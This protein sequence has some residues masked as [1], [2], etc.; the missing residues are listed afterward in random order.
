LQHVY[1]F[2]VR[3]LIPCILANLFFTMPP[4]TKKRDS[5]K[6]AENKA[7]NMEVERAAASKRPASP[8]VSELSAP[9][10]PAAAVA[11]ATTLTREM[12]KEILD[13]FA[14]QQRDDMKHMNE[15]LDTMQGLTSSHFTTMSNSFAKTLNTLA[16]KVEACEVENQAKFVA[17]NSQIEK[18]NDRLSNPPPPVPAAAAVLRA[19]APA[20]SATP[21][22]TS[23]TTPTGPA[24]DC[25]V[26]IRGFPT[27]QPGFILKEFVVE[28]LSVLPA[29]E[30]AE[31]RA[32]VSPADTQ[33]SLVFPTSERATHFV[34]LYLAAGNVFADPDGNETVLTCRT[35]KPLTLR[36]RG[37]L[38]RPIY[39]VLEDI[40][41]N[42]PTFTKATIS[43][44]S[45]ARNGVMT[46][47]FFALRARA[48]TPLFT[49]TFL[50]T[51]EAMSVDKISFDGDCPFT[52][53]ARVL[54]RAAAG[55]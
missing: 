21:S 19:S 55:Q 5:K 8:S 24:E 12:L 35:G 4:S 16:D 42:T 10:E 53:E 45:K 26:F 17:L 27:T 7:E 31:V 47:A 25:L 50:E 15:K 43:Q 48:L 23:R 1:T 54:L 46:T 33:F 32:R 11:E 3:K 20:S 37:G 30:R 28:A 2:L 41:R 22:P 44:T 13:G 6:E 38:I 52:E 39:T 51:P 9:A 36:R 29:A 18:I 34:T 14:T 49:L 40:L